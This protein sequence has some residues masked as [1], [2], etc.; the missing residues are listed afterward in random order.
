LNK[1]GHDVTIID[2]GDITQGASFGNAGYICPSHFIPLASPGIVAK[3]L[4][5]MLS[6]TSPFY[7]KPRMNVD[8]LRW[9]YIFW[10]SANAKTVLRNAPLLN[11]ILQMSREL[12]T[13]I[14]SELGNSFRMEEKGCFLLYKNPNTEKHE[15]ELAKVAKQFGIV[16]KILNGREVQQLEPK[17][18]IN[19][20]GGVLYPGDAHLHAGDFMK[21]LKEHLLNKGV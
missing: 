9:G 10:K 13:Q 11:N 12:M 8:L 15:I 16:T 6:S 1:S 19:V 20:R 18:E 14:K 21:T 5:W 4:G 2:R 3:G 7:I 17:V